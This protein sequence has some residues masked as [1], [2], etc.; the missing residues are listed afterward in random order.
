MA[1]FSYRG[2]NS[3]GVLVQG[4]IDATS[5]DAVATQ[6]LNTGITPIDIKE[7]VQGVRNVDI[8]ALLRSNRPPTLED[9]I[10][11][12]R[13][14]FTLM[15]AG[16]P[17]VRAFNGLIQATR[18]L[19]LIGVLRDILSNL[20]SGRDLSSSLARHPSIFS[21][22]YVSIVRVGEETGRLEESFSQICTYLEREKDTRERIKAAIRY[23]IF[24]IVA[25]GIAVTIINIWVIP[26]FAGLF[27]RA[28]VA[29]PWQT[30]LLIATSN[31]FINWWW[32]MLGTII[33]SVYAFNLYIRTEPGRFTWDRTRLR[34][35]LVGGII[36]RA[37]L[38]RFARA[39]SMSLTSGVP[40]IQAMTVVSRSVDNEFIADHILSMR[41]GIER[42]ESITR[43]AAITGIFTP[44]VLQMLSV[45][46]ETGQVDDLLGEVADYYEREVDYDIKNLS[47]AIEPIMIVAIGIM[48]LILAL[49]VFI[50][51]WDLSKTVR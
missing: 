21:S 27:E 33:G 43:T 7:A 42:G 37:T 47:A 4:S 22:L 44:L 18:N 32:A 50:P 29:L 14:M 19:R 16:V 23:P 28:G 15:K 3:R 11:F 10:L 46:E 9:M 20:E 35:P 1:I 48:V 24:V 38:S 49:G 12:S 36:T 31:F 51:L 40:L 45:G 13:Q 6:L 41:S 8:G 17:M 26:V 2:R 5:I 30:R 25:I 39:L 34:L